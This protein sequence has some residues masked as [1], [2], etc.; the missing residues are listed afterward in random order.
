[1]DA[2]D[3]T[4]EGGDVP[5]AHLVHVDVEGRLVELD[6]IHAEGGELPRFLVD[7]GGQRHAE[8][9]AAAVVG[10]VDGVGDGHGSRDGEL[11]AAP[12]FSAEEANL[13]G[14]DRTATAE[15]RRHRRHVRL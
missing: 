7:Q 5:V 12:G 13:V 10:V 9:R 6:H 2:L 15:R 8:L 14:V 3:G 4:V 1:G 11:H